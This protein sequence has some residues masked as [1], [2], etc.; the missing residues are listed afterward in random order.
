MIG[1]PVLSMATV[2]VIMVLWLF[3]LFDRAMVRP[4]IWELDE[5]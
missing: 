3:V 5:K 2:P 1:I 4:V